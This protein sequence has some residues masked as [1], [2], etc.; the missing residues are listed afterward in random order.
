[1]DAVTF[2]AAAAAVALVWFTAALLLPHRSQA[3]SGP[4]SPVDEAERIIAG[5]YAS[6]RITA[7]EYSRMLQVLRR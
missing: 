2:A 4:V 5:R 3:R 7:E 1:M 6:G